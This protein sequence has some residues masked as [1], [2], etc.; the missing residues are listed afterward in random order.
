MR[1]IRIVCA[2]LVGLTSTALLFAQAPAKPTPSKPAFEVASIKESAPLATFIA[3]VASGQVRTGMTITG[4]RFDAAMPLEALIAAAWRIKTTQIAG[5]DWLNSQRFEIRATLP[6]GAT[7]DQVPEMLQTLLEDRFKLKARLENRQQDAYALVLTKGGPKLEKSL[8]VD[9]TSVA[10]KPGEKNVQTLNTPA[11]PMTMKREGDSTVHNDPRT[12][13]TRSSLTANGMYRMEVL[14][15][16]MPAFADLIAPLIGRPVVDA[17]GL[18]GFYKMTLEYPPEALL[19]AFSRNPPADVAA[20]VGATPF[21]GRGAPS[22]SAPAPVNDAAD[23]AGR[24][25][26]AAVEK[27]GLKLDSRK[28]PIPTLVIE[29]IEKNPTEN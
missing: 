19:N 21:S 23:P 15:M 8:I 29:Q 25:V 16:S 4:N 26:F 7:K 3:Q 22:P 5:P 10:G 2:T 11:G 24:A 17:T 9:E 28:A 14:K 13:L 1:L 18:K 20:L 27:L 6:E 12:G